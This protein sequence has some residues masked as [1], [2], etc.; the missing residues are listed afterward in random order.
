MS[1]TVEEIKNRLSV[2]DVVGQYVKLTKAGKY[3][4]GLSPFNSEKT[5][6]FYVSPDR[7]LYHCFSS[8]KG[9]DMFTF[10]EEMEGVDFKGALKILAE[11][12][13]VEIVPESK[14]KKDKREKIYA[15]LKDSDDFFYE[16]LQK[17]S[18]AKEYITSRGLDV[19]GIERW[20]LGYV[21]DE[22]R[23]LL[24]HLKELG[25]DESLIEAAGLAKHPDSEDADTEKTKKL[26][27]RFRGR[28]M[29]PIRDVSGRVVGFS[30]RAFPDTDK[31]AKYLNSP[32]TSVFDKSR[33]LYGLDFAKSGIRKYNFTILVEGQFDL[34]MAHQAGYTNAIALSGT[35]FTAGHAA[36]I[37]RYTENLVLA[38][39]GDRAGVSASGRAA[40]IALQQGLNAKVAPLPAG[41]DPADIIKKDPSLWKD[42]I[43][44]SLHIVDFY[45]AHLKDAGYD[46]RRFKLE[47]SRTVL[48]YV[49]Q[50]KN[51][52][53]QSYFV[54]R[55]A[56]AIAVPEEAVRDELKK[57]TAS[58]QKEYVS[59]LP[60]KVDDIPSEPFLSKGDSLER[61]MVGVLQS[62]NEE[63]HQELHTKL[64]EKLN[65]ILGKERVSELLASPSESRA[66]VIEGDLFLE[67]HEREGNLEALIDEL[68]LDLEKEMKRA[69]FQEVTGK[70][71]RAEKEGTLEETEALLKEVSLLAREL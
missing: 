9:G 56:E 64:S 21:P 3:Y 17:N 44:Q 51:A 46:E 69:R 38:F 19:S 13:G 14:E 60:K 4:K 18:A 58:R 52:I 63:Q 57:L 6:S 54:G 67:N 71:R 5:A 48:P 53:D 62:L 42:S 1:D 61:L 37:R 24:E 55:V 41:E 39:D 7:G 12:A 20:H 34:L 50:I 25:H 45:I 28:I 33:V 10:V 16:T 68:L 59:P 65:S 31:G 32:E 43:R 36:L 35:A 15:I 40:H 29:F 26:Y 8:G 23:L 30:G 49:A 2:V 11:K 66:S 22:W 70:L 47:V 27:D